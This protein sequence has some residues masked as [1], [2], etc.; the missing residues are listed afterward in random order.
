MATSKPLTLFAG[1]RS[2]KGAKVLLRGIVCSTLAVGVGDTVCQ[3][4]EAGEEATSQEGT[5]AWWDR[6]R[7]LRMCT[8]TALVMSPTS[9]LIVM[10]L[11]RLFPGNT[12]AA[13]L[14]K[15]VANGLMAAPMISLNFATI[16]MLEG[17]F[18]SG[19]DSATN[20]VSA[21]ERFEGRVGTKLMYVCVYVYVCV[22]YLCF[23][24]PGGLSNQT[25]HTPTPTHTK[26]NTD[27]P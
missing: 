13:V 14:K 22:F 8:A 21:R 18:S 16:S 5:H 7:T 6:E 11:E 12:T 4:L 17:H 9:F 25:S 19:N 26:K 10:R 15:T 23:S 20:G 24:I 2:G 3:R 27:R 1:G